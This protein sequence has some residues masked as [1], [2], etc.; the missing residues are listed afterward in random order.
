MTNSDRDE[1]RRKLEAMRAR[2]QSEED[3]F[4][5]RFLALAP[6]EERDKKATVAREVWKMVKEMKRAR[7]ERA[8][9][10]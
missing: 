4:V 7:E 2:E 3:A 10:S 8:S 9:A 5:E 1:A 6:P